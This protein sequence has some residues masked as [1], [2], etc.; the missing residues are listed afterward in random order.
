MHANNR[1]L[2]EFIEK[3][4]P[5]KVYTLYGF[6][7]QLAGSVRHKLKIAARPLKLS[8]KKPTLIEYLNDGK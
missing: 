2:L 7:S 4:K 1:E 8:K 6:E 3:I 5:K